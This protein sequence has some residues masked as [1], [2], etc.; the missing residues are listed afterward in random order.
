[1]DAE[2]EGVNF[3][4]YWLT[5]LKRKW[6][7]LFITFAVLIPVAIYA[8]SL[9]QLYKADTLVMI[10]P[11]TP[12]VIASLE[13]GFGV[14]SG[15]RDFF[16]TQIELLRSRRLVD[17]VIRRLS[18]T[19]EPE[20]NASLKQPAKPSLLRELLPQEWYAM[21]SNPGDAD[22]GDPANSLD[23]KKGSPAYESLA[24]RVTDGIEVEA[25]GRSQLIRISFVSRSP[26]LAAKI[27]GSIAET[28][29]DQQLESKLEMTQYAATWL[30]DR[31]EG[32][33]QTLEKSEAELQAYRKASGILSQASNT[34]T[35]GMQQLDAINAQLID[36]RAKRLEAQSRYDNIV[37]LMR[38]HRNRPYELP[39]TDSPL[40]LDL[41]KELSTVERS[42]A[43][44]NE[45][46]GP[47]HP[48]IISTEKEAR[49]L[50][51]KIATEIRRTLEKLKQDLDVAR[52]QERQIQQHIDSQKNQIQNLQSKAFRLN[53]L[54]RE[55]EANRQLYDLFLKRFK[56]TDVIGG[57]QS[58]GARIVEPARVPLYS[59][60]PNKRL[61]ILQGLAAGLIL[62]VILVLVLEGMDHTIK[63]PE[64]LEA[65]THAP[66]FAMLPLLT[67]QRRDNAEPEEMQIRHPKSNY[68]EAVRS[69]R[70][71][72]MFSGIDQPHKVFMVTSAVPEEGKTTVA[73]NLAQAF[74]QGGERTL[75]IEAD[76]R[77]PRLAKIFDAGA[78]QGATSYLLNE[79]EQ[80]DFGL[81]GDG[82]TASSASAQ[83]AAP[84]A[85]GK[86]EPLM[87][88][89]LGQSKSIA[90][91][92]SA[93]SEAKPSPSDGAKPAAKRDDDA[94]YELLSR[95]II[96]SRSGLHVLV[97]GPTP[98][99]PSEILGSRKWREM[100]RILRAR[101]DR[102]IIDAPPTLIVTDSQVLGE[103]A[104]AVAF[105]VKA[106]KA[107]ST[108]VLGALK[109]LHNYR[110][111]V[112]G[113]VLNTVDMKRLSYYTNRYR[114][115][116][117]YGYGYGGYGY[118]YRGGYGYSYSYAK[119]D[120][121]YGENI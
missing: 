53:K 86:I 119:Q 15:G 64:E 108:T 18:L 72:L 57:L 21:L 23:F 98:P 40:L 113:C 80:S 13:E 74:N 11:D 117:G 110:I 111:N 78:D 87:D 33:R 100:L 93:P 48:R 42:L 59:F 35:M 68:S 50:R 92:A 51:T 39:L 65:L 91:S 79:I 52:E 120:Q 116:Y 54:E 88:F 82:E 47:K 1:M 25:V 109:R 63:T 94:E 71:A 101:Y 29:I 104:D 95:Y 83:T 28:Y 70:T 34:N 20:Y 12:K 37:S 31:L 49:Q 61:Y 22:Q 7:I 36:A 103:Q 76:L 30:T 16:L 44:L 9:P 118:G 73:I 107:N 3:S 5:I 56:E 10:E 55:V 90:A 84:S 114:Y 121:G 6:Q 115:G 38:K 81:V 43:E 112:V 67:K 58:A 8:Y 102:I 24:Q 85:G 66:M 60:K 4:F 17:E 62:G 75:L 96:E 77:R 97:S 45:R 26:E 46:Y 89:D 14:E 99:F 41:K 2:G 32:L 105:V 27:T 19:Q 106:N 69:L